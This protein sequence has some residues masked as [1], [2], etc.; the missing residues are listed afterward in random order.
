MVV[1]KLF[2]HVGTKILERMILAGAI[3]KRGN[4]SSSRQGQATAL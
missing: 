3:K 2:G 4:L 1:G